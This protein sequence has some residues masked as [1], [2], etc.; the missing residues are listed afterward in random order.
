LQGHAP[1]LQPDAL[2][3]NTGASGARLGNWKYLEDSGREHWFDLSIDPGE[4][5]DVRALRVD[6]FERIRAQYDPSPVH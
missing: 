6:E 5:N 4:K 1:A 3:A 2:L